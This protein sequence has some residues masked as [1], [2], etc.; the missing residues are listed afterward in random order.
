MT[1]IV[2]SPEPAEEGVSCVSRLGKTTCLAL[3]GR[4][5]LEWSGLFRQPQGRV[6]VNSGCRLAGHED[7]ELIVLVMVR[8]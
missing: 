2:K 5:G 1:W 6:E 7:L 4:W 8:N 3:N